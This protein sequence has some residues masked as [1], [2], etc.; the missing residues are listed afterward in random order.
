MKRTIFIIGILY[1]LFSIHNCLAQS[2]IQ[3]QKSYGGSLADD[4]RSIIQ[5]TDGGYIVAGETYSP[6]GDVI[7]L[8]GTG[9]NA[10]VVKLNITGTIQW[11]K[12]YGGTQGCEDIH[13]IIQTSDGGY[14]FA[15]NSCSND[16]DVSGNHGSSD[17]WVVKLND[18][19]VIQ[20]Q[21][22]YGGSLDDYSECIVQT[23]DGGFILVGTTNSNDGDV[24]GNHGSQDYWVVKLNDTGAIQWSKCY[25]GSNLDN[26]L[27]IK[28]TTDRG[29][30]IAGL[31]DSQDG[32]VTGNHGSQGDAWIIK[33]DTVGTIQWEK[34]YGGSNFD[35]AWSILQT[36]DGG[37]IFAGYTA[38][39]D[40]D[41]IGNHGGV[42]DF[43]VVKLSDTGATQW[44]K[45][46][47]GSGDDLAYTIL[48][49][50]DSTY[51][52]SGYSTSTDGNVTGNH[53]Y[54]DFW[55]IKLNNNGN[56]IWEKSYGGSSTD[57]AFSMT[58]TN[59]GGYAMA[60]WS[61][62]HD[63]DATLNHGSYDFWV[64]K[65]APD[66]TTGISEIKI[67]G[68][69]A[70]YPIPTDDNFNLAY[71][72]PSGN[73]Q[74]LITDITGRLVYSQNISGKSGVQTVDVTNLLNGVYYWRIITAN[75]TP[76]NG[77]IVV[78]K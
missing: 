2:V 12:C 75:E 60:G 19:G 46:Y 57:E 72:L 37:Y 42:E 61:G 76:P 29:Y 18:T 43:W 14:V 54:E 73:G 26:A 44:A 3:W 47:G 58:K 66:T 55:L 33:I 16:G 59:D 7:G 10:W 11:A 65:L 20:W 71:T 24:S 27:S 53:G 25:G 56:L 8:H 21:K 5:T 48:Q 23:I 50:S 39:I 31:S 67:E 28:Q 6:D 74:L 51:M 70:V 9:D 40:G 32:D 45:C 22:C 38:S 41:V 4:A 49:N 62:S 1:F 77:K 68:G 30:I 64:V 69:I 17:C 13:S 15:A 34:C 78:L 35:G 36:L 52:V 63:G